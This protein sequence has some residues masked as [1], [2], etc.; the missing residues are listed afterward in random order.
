MIPNIEIYPAQA[1]GGS[2]HIELRMLLLDRELMQ[3]NEKRPALVTD[4]VVDT[5]YELGAVTAPAA[6]MSVEHAQTLMDTLYNLGIRP[7]A[8][9]GSI[10][11]L[12]ATERHLAD[13][14]TI[15]FNQLSIP[16]P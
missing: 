16:T 4:F 15:A 13:M 1:W 5:S 6:I 3:L 8:A 2:R 14:R 12:S 11:Q 10:G 7:T 9:M